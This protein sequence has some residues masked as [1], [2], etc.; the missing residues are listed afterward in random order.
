MNDLLPILERI[1]EVGNRPILIIAEDVE[2]EALATLVV[3][4]LRGILNIAA[5]KA[6][7]MGNRRTQVLEDIAILTGGTIISSEL[8]IELKDAT[9]DML[10]S[11][12]KIIIDKNTTTIVNG[13]G[14][15]EDIKQRIS[16]IKKQIETTTSDYDKENLQERLAKLSGGVAIIYIGA[17]TETEMKEKKDRVV[18]ALHA[19]RAA[20]QEGIVLGGGLALINAAKYLDVFTETSNTDQKLGVDIISN[21]VQAP[22]RTIIKNA[23]GSPDVILNEIMKRGDNI[24]Y[25]ALTDEYVDM[26]KS[27]I[28][29]PTKVSRLAL[30]HASSIAG[31]LLTTECVIVHE[32]EETPQQLRQPLM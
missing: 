24:G 31:L 27:G 19:T 14:T 23:G 28:I 3:N 26:I 17:S 4:K 20:V 11:C 8:G 7:Y 2:S 21:A 16:I 25:N 6:P 1:G 29:D 13:N 30:E 12:E 22:F 10:G 32:K 9:I 5:V 15:S 18:D